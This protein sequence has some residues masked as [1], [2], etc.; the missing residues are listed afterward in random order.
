MPFLRVKT[1][2]CGGVVRC[3]V[4]L[5]DEADALFTSRELI[6]GADAD[7]SLEIAGRV[8]ALASVAGAIWAFATALRRELIR[9]RALWTALGLWLAAA[10]ILVFFY[11]SFARAEAA[12]AFAGEILLALCLLALPLASLALTPLALSWNRHR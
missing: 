1:H 5:I 3:A 12:P 10:L 2:K 9:R 8:L 4:L 7:S 6:A 11:F